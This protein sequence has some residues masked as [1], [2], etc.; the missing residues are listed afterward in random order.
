MQHD[1]T[2]KKHLNKNNQSSNENPLNSYK[3]GFKNDLKNETKV[4][5]NNENYLTND[6][7][8]AKVKN[9]SVLSK[10]WFFVFFYFI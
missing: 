6:I 2:G 4:K 1:I 5:A 9:F 3:T 7:S 8:K 10:K